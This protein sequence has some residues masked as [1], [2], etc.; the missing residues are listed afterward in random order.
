MAFLSSVLLPVLLLFGGG[1]KPDE[2]APFAN[3][4]HVMGL[5]GMAHACPVAEGKALTN[6][7][8]IQRSTPLG[9]EI[10][11]GMNYSTDNGDDGSVVPFSISSFRD[12][13][14]VSGP[15][16]AFYKIAEKIP[17]PGDK[18]RF[19]G[20]DL[21]NKK[22]AFATR[23]FETEVVR[24]VAGRLIMKDA[25]VLGSSG[26][27]VLNEAGEVVAINGF[28]MPVGVGDEVGGAYLVVASWKPELE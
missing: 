14:V 7:H 1:S 10:V 5:S 22:D 24:V 20:Y 16:K 13:A 4:L 6:A 11:D 23:V 9:E 25:G 19:I 28:G 18:V 26:S 27:C 21:R 8:V 2:V 3:V 12:L 15:F 17:L